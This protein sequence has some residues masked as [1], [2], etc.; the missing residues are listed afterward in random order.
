M[1]ILLLFWVGYEI[2][3]FFNW[4]VLDSVFLGAMLVAIALIFLRAGGTTQLGPWGIFAVFSALVLG[5]AGVPGAL[6][7]PPAAG[8]GVDGGAMPRVAPL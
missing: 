2:G 4:R 6:A 7:A 1:E 3:Q 8:V 5:V